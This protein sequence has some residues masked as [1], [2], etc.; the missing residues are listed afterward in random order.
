MYPVS[1]N[2]IQS[3]GWPTLHVSH[4][5]DLLASIL[6]M[7]GTVLSDSSLTA[8]CAKAHDADQNLSSFSGIKC[9][10]IGIPL[11]SNGWGSGHFLGGICSHARPATRPATQK[12]RRRK[13]TAGYSAEM[14]EMA[15]RDMVVRCRLKYHF[16]DGSQ[17]PKGFDWGQHW[18]FPLERRVLPCIPRTPPST[19]DLFD[20]SKCNH[21]HLL[22][23][24]VFRAPPKL[25]NV[26]EG[27]VW[28]ELSALGG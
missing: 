12:R 14:T 15:F 22:P 21:P 18:G 4:F 6:F 7:V 27:T 5:R 24:A 10:K 20:D 16:H 13:E 25:K 3:I 19:V 28:S 26:T 17:D 1:V 2:G 11:S 8:Q 23:S 9:N